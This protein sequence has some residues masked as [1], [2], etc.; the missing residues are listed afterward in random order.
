MANCVHPNTVKLKTKAFLY[1]L[2]MDSINMKLVPCS[3]L[4][5]LIV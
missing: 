4:D 3:V 1:F 2:G 5:S